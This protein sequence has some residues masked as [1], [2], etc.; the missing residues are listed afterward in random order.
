MYQLGI[1]LYE[2]LTG[3]RPFTFQTRVQGEIEKI[4]LE[5]A[6]EKPST[7][8]SR[9]EELKKSKAALTPETV[10]LKRRTPLDRLRKQ[11]SGDLD[12][13]VLMALRKEMDRRYQSADQL[14]LDIQNYL[15]GRPV[16][17]QA[18]T[19]AYRARKFVQRNKLGVSAAGVVVLM[20]VLTTIV[21]VRSAVITERQRVQ[22]EQEARKSHDVIDF[23]VDLFDK[24]NP[25][26]AQGREL[27]VRELLDLGAEDVQTSL[28]DH[29]EVQ[30]DLMRVLSKVYAGLGEADAGLVLA[31]A[32]LER[33]E[34][35]FGNED[36]PELASALYTM[37]VLK[38]DVGESQESK[39]YHKEA[40]A[41][42]RRLLGEQH[43]DVA[44]S[45]NDLG[46]TMYG[47]QAYDTTRVVWEQAL[48]I[49]TELL[50][51]A[52]RD[53]AESLSNLGAVS[54]DLFWQSGFEDEDLFEQAEDYYTR[55][56]DMTQRERGE[57]H[58]FYASNLHNL[59]GT[60]LDRGILQEAEN[61]FVEAIE[62]RTLIYGR[63]HNVTAR[64]INMLGRVR[65]AQGRLDEA[66]P[67][68]QESLDI[69]VDV[70]GSGNWIVGADHVQIAGLKLQQDQTEAAIERMLIA[71]DI[72]QGA[73]P[74]S[75][76]RIGRLGTMLGETM[77][78]EG[79]LAEAVRYF[80]LALNDVDS[81]KGITS[82]R[83]ASSY[84]NLA[85]VLIVTGR[86]QEA[87]QLIDDADAWLKAS[88]SPDQSLIEKAND[89]R[90]KL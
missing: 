20:L 86:N 30:S 50:G 39:K 68:F 31:E 9:V 76:P 75:H 90:A 57:N 24:A 73:F 85:R 72:Y 63:Y 1:L 82:A 44:Q 48:T 17:A 64:S 2:L 71:L 55:A 26:Y 23:M 8:I 47:L 69:H 83:Q 11:L 56:L 53:I 46:V 54:G 21:S 27:T 41:M 89:L 32:A 13:I 25:E 67:L 51:P 81:D 74:S 15:A 38:D 88:T 42:R 60:L 14:L 36:S 3:H 12:R 4:I 29:P 34:E 49:R 77:E 78:S 7:M 37:G 35:R 45:L 19:L 59:G 6:P 66:E 10:S 40:L 80:R 16:S 18:D 79:R 28:E 43:V 58:P 61:R 22:I 65:V 84:L 52:H 70:L 87:Q 33:E 5:Q 62:K